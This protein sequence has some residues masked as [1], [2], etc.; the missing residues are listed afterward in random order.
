MIGGAVSVVL[1]PAPDRTTEQEIPLAAVIRRLDADS[2][3]WL[4]AALLE[5][6]GQAPGLS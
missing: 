1:S 6:E 4:D 3:Q 2:R 5:S